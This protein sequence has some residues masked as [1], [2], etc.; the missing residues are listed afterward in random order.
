MN[1][2]FAQVA[3]GKKEQFFFVWHFTVGYHPHS[4][5]VVAETREQAISKVLSGKY[6]HEEGPYT[7]EA[8]FTPN[9]YE[10]ERGIQE[11]K[12]GISLP[13]LPGQTQTRFVEVTTIAE[14]I[15]QKEPE[16]HTLDHCISFAALDG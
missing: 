14:V 7:L 3:A 13:P 11:R 2:T 15:Q 8:P 5:V 1:R 4:F 16:V 6:L 9:Q 10:R 12:F